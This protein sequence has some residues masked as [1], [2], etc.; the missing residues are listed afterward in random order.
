MD[1][2]KYGGYNKTTASYYI[3]ARYVLAGKKPQADVM[4][5][6][7]TLLADGQIKAQRLVI[8][9]YIQKAIADIIGK[10]SSLVTEVTLPL[11]ARHIKI[12]TV[13]DIAGFKSCIAGK[14]S[15]G[16]NILLKSLM[17]L[18]LSHDMEIYV[19]K[20]ES[21]A[22]KRDVNR[23]L[24][25]NEQ[26]DGINYEENENLYELFMNKMANSPYNKVG[27]I[28]KLYDVLKNCKDKF[29]GLS[30]TEQT[31]AL[32]AILSVF[33]TGRSSACDL[34]IIGGDKA[35]ALYRLSAKLSNWEKTA[36]DVHLMDMSASGL[37]VSKSANLLEFL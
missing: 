21:F 36:N 13:I 23:K 5:V 2:E 28:A 35:A 9:D 12:N 33:Q 27:I 3:L 29:T 31:A 16:K 37:F 7:V 20:L 22:R 1:T 26:Y 6:P 25:V 17:P 32:L 30:L 24:E 34:S 4:F 8:N 15:G 19:K 10:D 14:N 18:V 11:G